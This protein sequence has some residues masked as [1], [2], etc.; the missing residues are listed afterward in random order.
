MSNI[1]WGRVITAA[2]KAKVPVPASVTPYQARIALLNVELL[3]TVD[4]LM[5]DPET[6]Q[7]ARIAWEYATSIE[8]QSPFIEALAPA[9]GLTEQ[10]IDDLFITAAAI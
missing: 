4:A 3:A 1:D 10:Q 6:D 2:D 7:A 8:R 9:L 5:A